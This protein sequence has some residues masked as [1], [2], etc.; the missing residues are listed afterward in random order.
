[1]NKILAKSEQSENTSTK[2]TKEETVVTEGTPLKK[3]AVDNFVCVKCSEGKTDPQEEG[4][5]CECC[6]DDANKDPCGTNKPDPE[7]PCSCLDKDGNVDPKK[8]Y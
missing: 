2:V 6:C 1:M 4:G 5:C 7:T 3:I 8:T